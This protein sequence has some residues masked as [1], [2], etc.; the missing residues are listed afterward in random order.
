MSIDCILQAIC[1]SLRAPTHSRGCRGRLLVRCRHVGTR[2]V[3]G[4]LVARPFVLWRIAAKPLSR[5]RP[6]SW[7]KGTASNLW[8]CP[9]AAHPQ[10][11]RI[12]LVIHT[13]HLL[14]ASSLRHL[15][16]DVSVGSLCLKAT[17]VQNQRLYCLH[18]VGDFCLRSADEEMPRKRLKKVDKAT[19]PYHMPKDK[20]NE[21]QAPSTNPTSVS[22]PR[23]QLLLPHT[24]CIILLC[25]CGFQNNSLDSS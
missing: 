10:S 5:G 14:S 2:T 4:E 20:Q 8:A 13:I 16:T 12:F 19:R 18:T 21:R 1:Q 9:L 17:L 11:T 24:N 25:F 15:P 7:T 6:M 22:L 3:L 23:L